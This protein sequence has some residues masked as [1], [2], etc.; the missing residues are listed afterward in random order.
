MKPLENLLEEMNQSEELDF[1]QVFAVTDLET[2]TEA[3]HRIS[4]F[5]DR[6]QEIDA[7]IEKQIA[8]FLDK[9][10][11]VKSWGEEA[12]KEFIEKQ[13]H[14]SIHL[15]M[16][17]REEVKKQ[18]DSGKK[19]KKTISL[20][21]G[22]ISLKKQQPEFKKDDELLMNYAKENGFIKVKESLDWEGIKKQSTAHEGV[23]IDEQGQLIP[24]VKVV[25][26]PE[27]FDLKLD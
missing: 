22:K 3:N 16:Y 13:A 12:K 8:P 17:L 1:Q 19:P 26:R 6:K 14:Y 15:E 21:Y 7:I 24:G 20:P 27:K 4:Y 25:E 18:I 23:L 9:I 2:A 10:E 11:K 5:E